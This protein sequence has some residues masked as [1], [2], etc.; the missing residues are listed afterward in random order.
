[1]RT[2]HHS[3]VECDLSR[4]NYRVLEH[5]VSVPSPSDS[6]ERNLDSIAVAKGCDVEE[7]LTGQTLIWAVIW[8]ERLICHTTTSIIL[9]LT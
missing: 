8:N 3:E 7:P 2:N 6:S 5:A 4:N 9:L 1:M